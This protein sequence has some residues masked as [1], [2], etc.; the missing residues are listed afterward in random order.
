LLPPLASCGQVEQS[1]SVLQ[2]LGHMPCVAPP[3]EED[4]EDPEPPLPEEDPL[5]DP[6]LDPLRVP[7]DPVSGP[8]SSVAPVPEGPR[9]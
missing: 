2:E 6:L 1:E 7:M 3:D 8:P 9:P 5:T 4:D